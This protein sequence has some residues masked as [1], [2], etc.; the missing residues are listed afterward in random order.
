MPAVPRVP[1]VPGTRRRRYSAGTK[2]GLV[3]A[4]E[5]LFATQGYAA[6]SLD[7]VVAGAEVTKGALY[8]HFDGKVALFEAVF[9]RVADDASAAVR[10]GVDAEDDPW[11]AARAGLRV[12]L[13]EVQ[14]E[15]YRRVVLHDGPAVLGRERY[16]RHEE[17]STLATVVGLVTGMVEAGTWALDEDTVQTFARIFFGAVSSAGEEVAGAT[18]PEA[19][20]ARVEAAIGLILDGFRVLA[21]SDADVPDALRG[22]S[23]LSARR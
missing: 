10:R 9:A 13:D 7:Q 2:Q 3:D 14:R 1:G 16:R 11:Q 17:R 5:T 22:V 8:H 18:D 15:R 23:G 20:A 12:F 19:A 6:T 4:A 21:E